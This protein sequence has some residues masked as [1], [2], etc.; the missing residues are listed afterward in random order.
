M[1][2]RMGDMARSDG[3]DDQRAEEITRGSDQSSV[4]DFRSQPAAVVFR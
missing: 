3:F 2:A 4:I 1:A